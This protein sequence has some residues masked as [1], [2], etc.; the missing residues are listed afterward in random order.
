MGLRV[1]KIILILILEAK[2]IIVLIN[3]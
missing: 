2:L 3:L 1:F